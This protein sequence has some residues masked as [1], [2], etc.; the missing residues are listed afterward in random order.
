ME[1]FRHNLDIEYQTK[2][3]VFPAATQSLST[4]LK[5]VTTLFL[6]AS[7]QFEKLLAEMCLLKLYPRPENLNERT[8]NI[9]TIQRGIVDSYWEI[10]DRFLCYFGLKVSQYTPSLQAVFI[11]HKPSYC[12]NAFD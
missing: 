11:F 8:S 12:A 9:G 1:L 7:Y 3:Q 10:N 6:C 5:I 2:L 4:G